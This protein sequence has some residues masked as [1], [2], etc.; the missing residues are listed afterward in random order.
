M[1]KD[2]LGIAWAIWVQSMNV[3]D[4]GFM[5]DVQKN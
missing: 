1:R 3:V 5:V 4:F 2:A